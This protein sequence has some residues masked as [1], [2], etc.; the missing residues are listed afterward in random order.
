MLKRQLFTLLVSSLFSIASWAGDM[1][2]PPT[3]VE[4]AKVKSQNWQQQVAATG[5]LAANQ[6]AVLRAE[7]DGRVTKIY[8]QPGQTVSEGAALIDINPAILEG[9]LHSLEAQ[10]KLNEINYQRSQELYRRK[11]YPKA[12]LDK[13]LAS[14]N[15]SK[16]D[17]ASA[18][19]KLAQA[20]IQAPF[21]GKIG[22]NR[23]NVGDYISAGKELVSLQSLDPMRVDFN[24]PEAY[25]STLKAGQAITVKVASHGGKIFQGKLTGV[26]SMVDPKTRSIAVRAQIPNPDQSLLPGAFADIILY[27]SEQKPVLTVP[28]QAVVYDQGKMFVYKVVNNKAVKCP[29]ELGKRI[30]NDIIINSGLA[31]NDI[32]VTAGQLKLQDQ[33]PVMVM[34]V[35]KQARNN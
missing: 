2:M 10:L 13:Q 34:P 12:E 26:D 21:A 31:A 22:L 9:Q 24:V 7:V 20:K 15:S 8:F 4:T 27:I 29:V 11:L 6:G 25:S 16:A 3:V 19:A 14:L 1:K 18:K 35:G 5:T 17:V 30:A 33:A 28:Q 32:V 23:V